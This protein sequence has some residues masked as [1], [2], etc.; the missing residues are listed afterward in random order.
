MRIAFLSDT[1]LTIV[2]G[3]L[4]PGPKHRASLR[5]FLKQALERKKRIDRV[6]L[7]GDIFDTW[8]TPP[9]VV[10]PSY[11]EIVDRHR[12]LLAC[13][14][15][16]AASDRLVYVLGNHDFDVPRGLLRERMPGATVIGPGSGGSHRFWVDECKLFAVHGHQYSRFNNVSRRADQLEGYPIGY[17]IGRLHAGLQEGRGAMSFG[18]LYAYTQKL[19]SVI[20]R[21]QGTFEALVDSVR[22]NARWVRLDS[23][24][25]VAISEIRAFARAMGERYPPVT[26]ALSAVAERTLSLAAS[27]ASFFRGAR[28]V[29]FGH[30]HFPMLN[31]PRRHRWF[32]RTYANAGCWC[33][34]QPHYVVADTQ[35]KT[36]RLISFAD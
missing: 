24:R 1:H 13:M 4:W 17:Y 30:T 34:G 23:N 26:T 29:V 36:L 11:E 25:N 27:R 6:V 8:R 2:R 20:R 35:R 32:S 7:L 9:H 16:L 33:R 5:A 12:D 14:A 15:R 19:N 31:E 28:T 21:R 3:R 10:P 18:Q 22:G